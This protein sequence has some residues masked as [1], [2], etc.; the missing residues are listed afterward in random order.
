MTYIVSSGALN[1]TPTNV[2]PEQAP[3]HSRTE[4]MS[5]LIEKTPDIFSCNS[6]MHPWILINL[7]SNIW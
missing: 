4:T 5:C 2:E 3:K 6:S 7:G 1:S